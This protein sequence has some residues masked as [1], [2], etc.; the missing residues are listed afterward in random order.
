MLNSIFLWDARQKISD[1]DVVAHKEM[2]AWYMLFVYDFTNWWK[3]GEHMSGGIMFNEKKI[4][5]MYVE[6][7]SDSDGE[8][9]IDDSEE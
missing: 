5:E 7:H 8:T 3:K 1:A 2:R 4:I 9:D 6:R